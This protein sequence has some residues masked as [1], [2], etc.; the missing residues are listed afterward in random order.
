MESRDEVFPL[1]VLISFKLPRGNKGGGPF[2]PFLCS[3]SFILNG[4]SQSIEIAP[5][6]RKKRRRAPIVMPKACID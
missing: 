2:R 5:K 3:L 4:M 1:L 6:R